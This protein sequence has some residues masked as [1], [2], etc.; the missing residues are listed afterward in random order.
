VWF[1]DGYLHEAD[2]ISFCSVQNWTHVL[3][4]SI[5]CVQAICQPSVYEIVSRSALTKFLNKV[6]NTCVFF[7]VIILWYLT[8]APLLWWIEKALY[9]PAICLS[10][11]VSLCPWAVTFTS[12]SQFWFLLFPIHPPEKT[13]K[14]ES[15]R[16]GYFPSLC[17]FA[18]QKAP[19]G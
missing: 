10:L 17:T 3:V 8:E 5:F 13:G 11:L 16:V 4:L 14:T 15:T 12:V 9:S 6:Q 1:L 7:S 2:T 18:L 19:E